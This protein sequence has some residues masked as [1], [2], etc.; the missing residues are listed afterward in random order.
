MPIRG[1]ME[2]R[3]RTVYLYKV[4]PEFIDE[5][6]GNLIIGFRAVIKDDGKYYNLPVY[7]NSYGKYVISNDDKLYLLEFEQVS[8]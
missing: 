7:E 2:L 5:L 1:K 3:T 6:F 8:K 4:Y